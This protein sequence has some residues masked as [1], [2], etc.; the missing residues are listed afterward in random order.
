MQ[1]LLNIAALSKRLTGNFAGR[2][3][4]IL[5]FDFQWVCP[6]QLNGWSKLIP[7]YTPLSSIPLQFVQRA[8]PANIVSRTIICYEIVPFIRNKHWRVKGRRKWA[9]QQCLNGNLQSGSTTALK[10]AICTS[11]KHVNKE[12]TVNEPMFARL[13]GRTAQW[14][15]TNSL[16]VFNSPFNPSTWT[17][18][19]HDFSA[20]SFTDDLIHDIEHRG[21]IGYTGPRTSRISPDHLSAIWNIT[22]TALEL[23]CELGLGRKIGPFLT[24]S[25]EKF[26]RSPMGTIPKKPWNPLNG[27]SF[28]IFG[29]PPVTQSMIPFLSIY[30]PAPTTPS[31]PPLL[32]LRVSV[33]VLWWV[34]LTYWTHS[35]T[36]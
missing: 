24:P 36:S 7:P 10:D 21:R 8:P 31:I 18:S 14:P 12:K 15:I 16:P 27:V 29:G 3:S 13:V 2:Q 20:L 4:K 19:L 17:T 35:V 9:P 23:E 25:V 1:S 5:T 28:T 34:N 32:L 6:A 26:V 22:S 30:F 11:K 33:K